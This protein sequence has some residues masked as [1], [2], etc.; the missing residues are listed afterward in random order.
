M[1]A[2]LLQHSSWC[3]H[4]VNEQLLGCG[5]ANYEELMRGGGNFE[6]IFVWLYFDD[7]WFDEGAIGEGEGAA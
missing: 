5:F 2:C 1:N 3:T 7:L 4:F 6:S